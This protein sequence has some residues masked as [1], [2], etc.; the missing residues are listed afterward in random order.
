MAYCKCGCGKETA[1]SKYTVASRGWVKGQPHEYVKGHRKSR[2]WIPEY[3]EADCGYVTRCWVW[4]RFTNKD[5]Y[6]RVRV[7]QVGIGAHR[8]I[9]ERHR[10]PIP[11]GLQLDHLCRNPSCVNPEHL[12]PVSCAINIHRGR[13]TKLTPDDILAIKSYY[14]SGFEQKIIAKRFGI[15]QSHVSR[16]VSGKRWGICQT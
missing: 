12:Q 1:I 3:K 2:P 6:G 14:E 13:V 4:Q 16:I 9:Y 8:I 10:G 5:G 15:N 7:G 11:E